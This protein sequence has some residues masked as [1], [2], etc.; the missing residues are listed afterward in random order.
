MRAVAATPLC[1]YIGSMMR[2]P[3]LGIVPSAF[4]MAL[5]CT[6]MAAAQPATPAPGYADLADLTL[7]APVIVRATVTR[8]ER[9]ADRDSP[10]L[11]PGKARLLVTADTA[12]SIV[13]PGAVPA[14]QQWLWDAPL[15]ARGKVPKLK[16]ETV[17]AW[18]TVADAAGNSRLVAPDG[19]RLW[20]EAT[21]TRLRSIATEAKSGK[22]PAITGVTNGFRAE[23]T[24]PG[25]AESQFFLSTGD[26]KPAALIVQ[27]RPG[28]SARVAISRSDVID[29]SAEAVKPGT[30]LWYRLACGL[31]ATLPAG[32]GGGDAALAADWRLALT[33]LGPCGRS[34]R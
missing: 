34:G 3:S 6:A 29:E 4:I 25:E 30:L 15:D 13:A 31:P 10:G 14:R 9:I 18:L 21:A 1:P 8:T 2:A 17:I 33:A 20:D 23:G 16:G 32:A 11:A 24:V 5:S 7:A 22:V 19:Q 28:E 12:A 26:G 27:S